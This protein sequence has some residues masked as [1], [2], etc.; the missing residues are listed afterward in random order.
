MVA[1]IVKMK[2]MSNIFQNPF[3][4]RDYFLRG[5]PKKAFTNITH[6]VSK[7]NKQT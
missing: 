4:L 3:T 1:M 7:V 2:K 5:I 6:M